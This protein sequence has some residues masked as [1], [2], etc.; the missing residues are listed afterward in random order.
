MGSACRQ[1]VW[2]PLR[3]LGHV[4]SEAKKLPMTNWPGRIVA[5]SLPT[6]STIPTYSWPMCGFR[7][8][9]ISVPN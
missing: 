1:A 9:A 2:K 8:M 5:T 7:G 4:P 3:Q 6:S